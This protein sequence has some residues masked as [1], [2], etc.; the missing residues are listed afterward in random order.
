M[1]PNVNPEPGNRST[2]SASSAPG[3]VASPTSA[4]TNAVPTPAASADEQAA[5]DATSGN[6]EQALPSAAKPARARK[7]RRRFVGPPEPTRQERREQ[8][9]ASGDVQGLWRMLLEAEDW[10]S[11]RLSDA[12]RDLYRGVENCA[13]RRP[14]ELSQILFAQMVSTEAYI[15]LRAESFFL[16]NWQTREEYPGTATSDVPPDLVKHLSRLQEL[17]GDLVEVLLAQAHAARMWALARRPK[18][19]QLSKKQQQQGGAPPGL[20]GQLN[21]TLDSQRFY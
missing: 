15:L 10:K 1:E 20:N 14:A 3:S 7:P 2:A 5:P 11:A 18:R 12:F 16:K 4:V 8:M 6:S 21:G 17:R 9:A 19:K 13:R